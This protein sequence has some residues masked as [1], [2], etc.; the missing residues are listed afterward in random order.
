MRNQNG[1]INLAANLAAFTVIGVALSGETSLILSN[2][3]QGSP[4]TTPYEILD[5]ELQYP[6]E[7]NPTYMIEVC[8]EDGLPSSEWLC[9]NCDDI[10][11]LAG[12][13]NATVL[14]VIRP[15]NCDDIPRQ[16]VGE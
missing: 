13:E 16:D 2:E 15:G 1:L 14:A 10:P 5:W 4:Y 12:Q 11:S 8:R 6:E 3:N 9:G 7:E